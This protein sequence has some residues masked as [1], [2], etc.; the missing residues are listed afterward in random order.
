MTRSP[1]VL[2]ARSRSNALKRKDDARRMVLPSSD[3]PGREIRFNNYFTLSTK[4]LINIWSKCM[5]MN[6][7]F[8]LPY[9]PSLLSLGLFSKFALLLPQH[10]YHVLV[11]PIR[12]FHFLALPCFSIACRSASKWLPSGRREWSTI[13]KSRCGPTRGGMGV[14]LSSTG[15]SL[16]FCLFWL[17]STLDFYEMLLSIQ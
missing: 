16:I 4:I 12:S 3:S 17:L 14:G 13:K 8:H 10:K 6:Y 7:S 15:A 11:G 2:R 1:Q 9:L 5:L